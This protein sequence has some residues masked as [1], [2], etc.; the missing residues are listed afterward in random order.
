VGARSLRGSSLIFAATTASRLSL[1]KETRVS[2]R[3][4]ALSPT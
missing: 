4:D 2:F 1:R 3:N